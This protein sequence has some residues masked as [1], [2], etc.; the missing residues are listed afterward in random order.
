VDFIS[1][2]MRIH[3][4][5]LFKPFESLT[6]KRICLVEKKIHQWRFSHWGWLLTP[7]SPI[8]HCGVIILMFL[9]ITENE[10]RNGMLREKEELLSLKELPK[11]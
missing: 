10:E 7:S 3:H 11:V 5:H 2:L 4:F 8:D 1:D 9:F 6:Y